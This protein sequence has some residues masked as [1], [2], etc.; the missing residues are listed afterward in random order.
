[1]LPWLL[2]RLHSV[3][4]NEPHELMVIDDDSPDRTWEISE[5]LSKTSPWIRSIRRVGERGL[6]SAVVAGFDAAKG[7][8]LAVLDADHSHDESILPQLSASIRNGA[9]MAVGSR[10]IPGGGADKWPWYRRAMSTLATQFTY[11]A[12]SVELSDPMSGFFCISRTFYNECR[13]RLNPMG[14]KILLSLYAAGQPVR[15]TEHAFVF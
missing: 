6:S 12:L 14:Y 1:N 2:D 15:V 7:N 4:L 13:P 11:L 10:R 5:N 9:Q 8:I 3:L